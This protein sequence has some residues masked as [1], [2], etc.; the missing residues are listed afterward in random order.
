[1]QSKTAS[2]LSLSCSTPACASS[3]FLLLCTNGIDCWPPGATQRGSW[4]ESREQP[5][6]RRGLTRQGSLQGDAQTNTHTNTHR[7]ARTHARTRTHTHTH[8]HTQRERT[9][10]PDSEREREREKSVAIHTPVA[11]RPGSMTWA[12]RAGPLTLSPITR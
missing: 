10:A 4:E 1:M 9:R 5:R 11:P 7:H 3:A 12:R 8:T 2:T 6:Q